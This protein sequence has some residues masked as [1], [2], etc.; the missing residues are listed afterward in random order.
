[1]TRYLEPLAIAANI[2]QESFCRMDQVLLTF[3]FL[4]MKYRDEKMNQDHIGRDA[5]IN[6]VEARWNKSDQ[7]I[8]IS[9]VLVNPFYR[10]APFS[11]LPVFSKAHIRVLFTKLYHRFFTVQPP[12]EFIQHAYDFLDGRGFFQG[13]EGQVKFELEAALN[14]VNSQKKKILK[15]SN[16]L[17][18]SEAAT[19]SPHRP[20]LVFNTRSL[21]RHLRFLNIC[22]SATLC[23]RQLCIMREAIQCFWK[24]FN[25]T[26]KPHR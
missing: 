10:T 5:I 24:H 2:V 3:G 25:K 1:M 16:M 14:K 8:F 7:E 18:I 20:G 23:F 6:S 26:S 13:L 15:F 22:T 11:A 21:K 9:T 19:R 4:V 17:W 12:S